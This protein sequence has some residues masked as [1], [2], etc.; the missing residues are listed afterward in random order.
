MPRLLGVHF[1]GWVDLPLEPLPF[2]LLVFVA[3]AL[4]GFLLYRMRYLLLVRVP[5]W[6]LAHTFYRV[7]LHGAEQLPADGGV[8]LVCNPLRWIHA[9]L[10]LAV[11]PR[12][13][14]FVLWAPTIRFPGLRW[15]LR[16]AGVLLVESA[17]GPR[18]LLQSL[19]TAGDALEAGAVVCLVAE[20][21]SA[22]AGFQ[23]PFH[24]SFEQVARRCPAPV[25]PLHI[26]RIWGNPF[27][28]FG[29]RYFWP[30]PLHLPV[31]IDVTLGPSLPSGAAVAVVRQA[32]QVLAADSAIRLAAVRRPV[33]RQF[34]RTAARHP[35]WP[36]FLDPANDK[37]PVLR[38]AEVLVGAKILAR[39]L[40]P[41]LLDAPM[42]GLW[43]PATV[44]GAIANLAVALLGKTAVNLNYTS[45]AEGVQSA[46]RQCHLTH[47]L[48]ARLFTRK[49]PLDPGPGV[50]LIA[51]EDFRKEVTTWQRLR[52]LLGVLLLPGW[53]QEYWQLGLGKHSKDHVAAV[54]FS[55]GSTGEPKGVMLT[56]GNIAANADAMIE[57]IRLRPQDRAMAVLPFFH[58]FGFTVTL[59]VPLQTGT[60]IV[61][62][63]DPRQAQEIG[64]IIRKHHC[65]IYLTT[66]TFLRMCLRRCQPEDFRSLRLLAVGAE[67]LAPS[68][69]QEFQAKFG[70]EPLEA[71][72]CTELS[73]A[74][75]ANLPD[76]EKHGRKLLT[77]KPGTI[78][79]PI[80][81]VAARVV[82]PETFAPL[83]ADQEG[84]LL[85]HGPNVM[86]GYLDKPEAT[87]AVLRDGWYITGDIARIDEDGFLTITDRLSRFSKIGGEMVP[88]Q[89][90]EDQLHAILGTTERACVVTAVP[91]E[92]KGER[93]VV[94][95]LDLN[96][97]DIHQ[98]WEKLLGRGLPNLWIPRE[99]DFYRIAELPLLG[100]GKVDLKRVKEMALERTGG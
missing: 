67:K 87:A 51:L 61:Y 31:P 52:T 66:P 37:K 82:H 6:L 29:A 32:L 94:L 26:G 11:L 76:R 68:L 27:N 80:P 75:T 79:Q 1:C 72:G 41:L 81:G 33:H 69:A 86:K 60:S 59:W 15:F 91:D 42:V 100:S 21:G 98:L 56:H 96:G 34:V 25:L 90:I 35:F 95:H 5:L 45:S 64:E 99:R 55:S 4:A 18:G 44:G 65:T 57:A 78:G 73:P 22:S 47:I 43:L 24:T 17:E 28:Y 23:L 3:L 38:Y 93:L 40:R 20:D 88:H 9:G 54:I 89:K 74:A 97:L 10:L 71:Y 62:F 85:V 19:R 83:P 84:L 46:I 2:W 92:G 7:R 63:P 30:L 77:H 39:K 14:R 12:R 70:I 50:E 48:T 58:S 13:V 53:V 16:Q 49:M 8:L 36:C